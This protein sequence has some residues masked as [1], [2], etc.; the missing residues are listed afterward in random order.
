VVLLTQKSWHR[1]VT[2]TCI[3]MLVKLYK[4][5]PKELWIIHCQITNLVQQKPSWELNGFSYKIKEFCIY[6]GCLE[7]CMYLYISYR[8]FFT[9]SVSVCHLC[10]LSYG[11]SSKFRQIAKETW[12]LLLGRCKFWIMTH[13]IHLPKQ[14]PIGLKS[15]GRSNSWFCSNIL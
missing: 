12:L 11:Q 3:V 15:I 7:K 5:H 2:C 10:L 1:C 14:T 8:H 4:W 9:F 6:K 13:Y